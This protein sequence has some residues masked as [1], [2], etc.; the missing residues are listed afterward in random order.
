MLKERFMHDDSFPT[1]E[2]FSQYILSQLGKKARCH[3]MR[4]AWR[5]VRETR[6]SGCLFRIGIELTTVERHNPLASAIRLSDKP[7]VL[8]L[9]AECSLLAR[10]P[11]SSTP[12]LPAP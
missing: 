7:S 10:K 8:T 9:R 3:G 5:L 6:S 11:A 12:Y 2:V 1:P 4:L